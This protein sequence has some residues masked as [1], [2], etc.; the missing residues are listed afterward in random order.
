M[1]RR[2]AK[3]NADRAER[4]A[5]IQASVEAALDVEAPV[6]SA[7][8]ALAGA[9]AALAAAEESARTRLADVVMQ[10]RDDHLSAGEI[11]MLLNR[12]VRDVQGMIRAARSAPIAAPAVEHSVD[13]P[14]PAYEGSVVSDA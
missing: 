3:L 8:E 13:E 4:D 6:I 10:L 9:Q 2:L 12:S 7:R 14:A 1:R 5:R 11:A